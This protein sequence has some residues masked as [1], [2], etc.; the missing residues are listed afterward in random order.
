MSAR[1]THWYIALVQN[2]IISPQTNPC[3]LVNHHFPAFDTTS[4]ENITNMQFVSSPT[5]KVSPL[6]P[7]DT[8][9]WGWDSAQTIAFWSLLGD[10]D[11]EEISHQLA[12]LLAGFLYVEHSPEPSPPSPSR[13]AHCTSR[14]HLVPYGWFLTCC[15]FVSLWPQKQ[16]V[17]SHR[18]AFPDWIKINPN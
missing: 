12:L 13:W 2:T 6:S 18:S 4:W 3:P 15:C 10:L 14:P 7:K 1:C 9:W 17:F 8:C 5:G 16:T 11:G